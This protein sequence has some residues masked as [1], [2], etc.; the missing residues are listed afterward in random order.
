MTYDESIVQRIVD[1]QEL[2]ETRFLAEF[3]HIV[4]KDRKKYWHDRHIKSNI[5]VQGD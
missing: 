1:L 2:E 4:E 5:F 3:H